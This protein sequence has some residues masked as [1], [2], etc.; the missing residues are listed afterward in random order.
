VAFCSKVDG[1]QFEP[2]QTFQFG[3]ERYSSGKAVAFQVLVM[4]LSK[5]CN[6]GRVPV[7]QERIG[8]KKQARKQTCTRVQ[9]SGLVTT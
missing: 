2:L 3:K 4:T 5:V 6:L 7:K 9:E 1:S 8:R